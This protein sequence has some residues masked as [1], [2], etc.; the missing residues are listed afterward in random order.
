VVTSRV[1]QSL[2]AVLAL[3]SIHTSTAHSQGS[4]SAAPPAATPQATDEDDEEGAGSG[5]GSA[6]VAPADPK[7][8]SKWL[9][10]QLDATVAARPLLSAK[11]K[12]GVSI[13][14][15]ETGT[16]LYARDADKGMS[17]AS[18]AKL[19][20]TVAALGT[21]GGGFRW[22]TSVFIDDKAFDE[23]TG[24]VKGNLYVRGKGDPT[25][26]VEDLRALAVEVAARGIRTV[27]GQLVIDGSYFDDVVDAPHFDEQPKERAAFRAPVA[28]FEVNRSAFEVHVIGEPGGG[29]KVW[30]EPDAGD[31]ITL[32]KSDVTSVGE[33]RTRIKV[34]VKPPRPKS[35]LLDIEVSGQLR[36]G[37]GH[38]WAKRRVDDPQR[39]AAEVF[40]RALADEG[41]KVTRK[42]IGSAPLPVNAQAIASHDSAPL[43]AV[44]REMNKSSDNYFAET[45]LKT[46]GAETRSTP[47]PATWAD[48]K[49]AVTVFLA[50]LGLPPGTY[51]S[52]NGSGLFGASEVAPRQ[53]VTLLRGAYADYRIGPD[54]VGSLP[55]GGVDGTL[56]KRWRGSHAQGRVR[57]KTG[58]LAS[59]V[60]LSGYVAVDGKRPIAFTVLVNDIPAGQKGPARAMADDMLD[61]IV[62]YLEAASAPP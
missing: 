13:V 46:L 52:D 25:L 37:D 45:V 6:R 1:A 8:R 4:G 58:T 54:L 59:V 3:V 10:E 56:A 43:A 11:A 12:I 49:A 23:T 21:L 53:M 61:V 9:T 47:G 24:I 40:R 30:V 19:L 60:T 5:S 17:L 16:E 62:A 18:N 33:G 14:D 38:Y 44:V 26:G 34:E 20:T 42:A 39:F 51:R 36:L 57:A 29:T 2:A 15:L 27:Q 48:G 7:A 35:D 55:V 32:K 22:R 31:L 41:V 28:A 50:K